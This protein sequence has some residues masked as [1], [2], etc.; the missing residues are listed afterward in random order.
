MHGEEMWREMWK[1]VEEESGQKRG[2]RKQV[3][4]VKDLGGLE[5][6]D[7]KWMM[8]PNAIGMEIHLSEREAMGGE[9]SSM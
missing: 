3:E 7:A 2:S 4:R 1:V 6:E 8:G 5:P 9:S